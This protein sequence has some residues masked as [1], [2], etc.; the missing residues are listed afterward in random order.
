MCLYNKTV[1]FWS[2]LEMWQGGKDSVTCKLFS[3]MKEPK[4]LR[5]IE[6]FP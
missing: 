5:K 1:L 4:A 3:F 2:I 6:Y